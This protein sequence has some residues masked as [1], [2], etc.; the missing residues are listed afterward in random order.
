MAAEVQGYSTGNI[1]G[2]SCTTAVTSMVRK[3]LLSVL[4]FYPLDNWHAYLCCFCRCIFAF[5][6]FLID[7]VLEKTVVILYGMLKCKCWLVAAV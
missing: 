2:I 1:N 5:F 6:A 3:G 7:L 4:P